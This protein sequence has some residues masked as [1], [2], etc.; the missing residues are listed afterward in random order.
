M[1]SFHPLRVEHLPL[2]Q[3]WLSTPHVDAWWRTPL[4]AG[5]IRAKYGPR[6]DGGDPTHVFLIELDAEPIGFIQWYRWADYPTHAALLGARP[7]EA[8]IDLAIGE[9]RMLGR[10]LGVRAIR[11]FLEDV[12]ASDVTMTA[13]LADPE[14]RNTRSVRAFVSAGF[15][16]LRRVQLPEED[17]TREV[18]R[19]E[20][21]RGAR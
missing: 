3:G 18:V 12:V 19:R 17:G 7:D 20:L 13:C 11:R 9:P 15:A 8:G 6:I 1:L 4:D 16:V 2:M 21:T 10:G 5:G 14:T